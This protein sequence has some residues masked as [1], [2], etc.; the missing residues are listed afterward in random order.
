[1]VKGLRT[2]LRK[3]RLFGLLTKPTSQEYPCLDISESGLQLATKYPFP[4][5]TKSLIL[6]DITI[7]L[8]RN[9]PIRVKVQP[10][11][12][13]PSD[14]LSFGR[15]GVQFVSLGKRDYANLKRLIERCGTDKDKILS[16]IQV[17]MIKEDSL[18]IRTMKGEIDWKG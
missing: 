4:F 18:F 7:P 1:M 3:K 17:K 15:V 8:T 10:V 11:W 2:R 13:K 12:F 9:N 16:S 5:N 6:L 14:D